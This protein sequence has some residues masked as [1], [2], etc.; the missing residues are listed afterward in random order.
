M[1]VSSPKTLKNIILFK[2]SIPNASHPSHSGVGTG[3]RFYKRPEV[4]LWEKTGSDAN[5]FRNLLLPCQQNYPCNNQ[6]NGK[7]LAHIQRH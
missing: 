6:R 4:R 1:E 2:P 3:V 7:Y 5:L